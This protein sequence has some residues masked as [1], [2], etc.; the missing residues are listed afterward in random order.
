MGIG[1]DTRNSEGEIIFEFGDAVGMA[2]CN[3][4]F[5]EGRL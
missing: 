1:F 3:P 4:F 2:V 5:H